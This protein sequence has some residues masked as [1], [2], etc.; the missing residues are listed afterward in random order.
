MPIR[1][2]DIEASRT[3]KPADLA[4]RLARQLI[5]FGI[6]DFKREYRFHPVRKWRLDLAFPELRIGIE[7][8][9]VGARGTAGRHQL[10]QH[11][12]DNTEKHSALAVMGWRLIRVTGKQIHSGHAVKWITQALADTAIGNLFDTQ[13]SWG[14]SHARK[15][16]RR[17]DQWTAEQIAE[18]QARAIAPTTFNRIRARR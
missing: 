11:I 13:G 2:T 18:A 6:T 1:L 7:C 9:G 8:E 3:R 14:S 5:F 17:A 12:H 10:T 4:D 16:K 15:R